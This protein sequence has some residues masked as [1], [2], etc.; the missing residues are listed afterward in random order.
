MKFL[1]TSDWH[2]GRKFHGHSTAEPQELFCEQIV[3]I[4]ND[5]NVDVVL[6]AGDVYDRQQPPLESIKLYEKTIK[7]ILAAGAKI[8]MISGNHDSRIRLGTLGEIMEISGFYL[9]TKITDINRPLILKDKHG[10]IAVY[11]I[12]YIQPLADKDGLNIEP[13][14]PET[15]MKAATDLIKTDLAG[16]GNPRSIV[17]SHSFVTGGESSE[18]ER[19]IGVGGV[20][21]VSIKHFEDF[22]Y[23]A[24]GH[25]HGQQTLSETVRYS[26]SPMPYSFN[27]VNQD[28]GFWLFELDAKGLGSIKAINPSSYRELAVIKGSLA[29]LLNSVEFNH[30]EAAWTQITV[31]Q[32]ERPERAF[33]KLQT[34]FKHLCVLKYDIAKS[35]RKLV[36][37]QLGSNNSEKAEEIIGGFL[38][39]VQ[40]RAADQTQKELIEKAVSEV[41][42]E[43]VQ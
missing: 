42:K 30:A 19:S 37:P 35:D 4:I 25:L 23:S 13:A 26:G 20:D 15:A 7:N 27:E 36:A 31:K 34:R 2:L 40:S 14:N 39:H 21:S 3:K 29:E 41:S 10:D 12:P 28:K 22:N 43:S 1:H 11:G 8:F 24:L 5:E 6:V 9:R 16:R 38:D 33:D 17:L 18:S 32:K